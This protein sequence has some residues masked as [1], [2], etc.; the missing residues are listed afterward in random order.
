MTGIVIWATMATLGLI[1]AILA[2]YATSRYCEDRHWNQERKHA[3]ELRE[4]R[5][6]LRMLLLAARDVE[7]SARLLKVWKDGVYQYP[8]MRD[9]RD[10][11]FMPVQYVETVARLV[12]DSANN[13]V[14]DVIEELKEYQE[15]FTKDLATLDYCATTTETLLK[16]LEEA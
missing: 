6:Q 8:H 16:R 2:W 13:K 1:V 9:S 10:T 7:A 11:I 5:Q 14:H 4:V 12:H 15:G 3:N